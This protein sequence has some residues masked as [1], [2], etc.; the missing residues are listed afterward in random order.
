MGKR[1]IMRAL[2]ILEVSGVDR[3]AQQHARAATMKRD[4]P[5]V[6]G[7]AG[8]GGDDIEGIRARL[9]LAYE[10]HRRS[11]PNLGD[12]HNLG[13]AWRSLSRN[14]RSILL[15]SDDGGEDPTFP[16][17]NLENVDK[18]DARTAAIAARHFA[19]Q[20]L[21]KHADEIRKAQ[22]AL[23]QAAARIEARRRFPEVAARE[24]G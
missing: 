22:L 10:D 11:C 13:A 24:R 16:H 20:L 6:E 4:E 1:R 2:K 14:D 9:R 15:E 8:F 19:T 7:K 21:T 23:S 5:D 12:A 3:P 18:R 17:E